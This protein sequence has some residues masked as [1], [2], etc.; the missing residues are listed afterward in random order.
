MDRAVPPHAHQAL[1]DCCSVQWQVSSCGRRNKWS[2]EEGSEYCWSDGH[3]DA[4]V[5]HSQQPPTPT[6]PSISNT[7]WG[8]G[9]HTGRFL[10]G[11]QI[12]QVS[13]HLLTGCPPPV[14]P[15]TVPGSSTDELFISE[16]VSFKSVVPA[17]WYP[18][19]L[20][21][22][23]L[24]AWTSA[25]SWWVHFRW[26]RVECNSH[27][28]QNNQLL[29]GHQPHGNSSPSIS[30]GSPPTK[31]T[32]SSGWVYTCWWWWWLCGNRQHHL[33]VVFAFFLFLWRL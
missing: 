29:G 21:S 20:L 16:P 8:P 19:F 27:V 30:S 12:F 1:L 24:T 11:N 17:S 15:A 2:K 5:V 14:L 3:R 31:W 23:C 33:T 18:I 13:I 22:M 26:R 6:L 4:T 25:D 7:L 28:Q 10:W 9:L 32:H